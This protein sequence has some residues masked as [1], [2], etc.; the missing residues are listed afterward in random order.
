MLWTDRVFV[1]QDDLS[2]IDSEVVEVANSESITLNGSNGLLRGAIEECSNELQ[3]LVTSFGGYLGSGDVSP[4][5]TAAVMNIGM[6]SDVR[7]KATLSQICVSGDVE[8]SWNWVKQWAVF[9]SLNVLYRDAFNRTVKDRYEGKMRYYKSELQRRVTPSIMGLGLPIVLRPLASPAATFERDSG[10]WGADNVT[11]VAGAGTLDAVDRDVVVTYVDMTDANLYVSSTVRNN[12][13]S[14][15]SERMTM[16]MT[17]GNVLHVDITSLGPPTGVQHP[18]QLL[19]CVVSP[20]RATHWNVYVGARAGL[21]Y[22]QNVAP[23][24]IATKTYT[25]AADPLTGGQTPGIGQYAVKRLS[26]V[27]T[28]QRA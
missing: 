4:N 28:R 13:E 27:P 7:A 17:T 26:L 19:V 16:A 24:T 14:H 23:I 12:A 21:L 8:D 10:T 18:S 11:L 2:R 9:W 20:M 6:G 1:T 15:P 25:L 22:L 3:K 5:H